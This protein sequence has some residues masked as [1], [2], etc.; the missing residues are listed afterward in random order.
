MHRQGQGTQALRVRREGQPGGHAP[1]RPDGGCPF[2]PGQPHDGHT[3]A[4]QL[5]QTNTLLQDIGVKPTTADVDLR[6]NGVDEAC[7]PAQIIHRGKFKPLDAQ[8]WLKRR[9]A[10]E[11]AVGHTKSDN[12]M[13][14]CLL[15]GSSGGALHAVLCAARFNIRWL[16]RAI[17]TKGLAALLLVFSQLA[18]HAACIGNVLQIPTLA[19]GRTDRQLLCR[20]EPITNLITG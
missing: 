20:R 6:F 13:D 16:L 9:Q 1:A 5:E 4:E 3:L 14:R 15:S 17:A 19:T 7:A 11:P 18:S 8:Q 10:I 2:F 12:R